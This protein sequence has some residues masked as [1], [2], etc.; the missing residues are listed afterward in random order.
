[1][2][3]SFKRDIVSITKQICLLSVSLYSA[4]ERFLNHAHFLGTAHQTAPRFYGTYFIY[5]TYIV[6]NY[7]A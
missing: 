5:K 4:S 1:L 2:D 7:D 3:T 6:H